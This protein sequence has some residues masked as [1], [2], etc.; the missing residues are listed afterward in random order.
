EVR[1]GGGAADFSYGGK[2]LKGAM[3]NANRSGARYAIV[4]GERDLAEGVVQLKDM[5]SGEQTAVG[6][7][8]IVA[9]LES[10]LG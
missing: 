3:K 9:E 4:A 6:V 10:R 5:E 2:G 1:G 7:N 8:E